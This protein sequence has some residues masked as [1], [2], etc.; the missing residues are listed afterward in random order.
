M[1]PLP[2][3]PLLTARLLLRPYEPTDAGDFFALLATEAQ[4]LQSSF[5]DRLRTIT[6]L[7][8]ALQAITGFSHDWDT[9]RFYVFGIWDR[10]TQDYLGDICLMPHPPHSGEI[11]YYL[12]TTAEGHGYAREAL[13]AITAFGLET[14]GARQLLIRCFADNLRGQG[15]ARAIGFKEEPK[16]KPPFWVRTLDLAPDDNIVRFVLKR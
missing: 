2:R 1:A 6:T 13:E 5:P 11:G 16:P 14:L 3:T 15:V 12:S 10:S 9:G 4:R 7:A 8:G